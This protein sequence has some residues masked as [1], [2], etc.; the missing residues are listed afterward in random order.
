M[1]AQPSGPTRTNAGR[2]YAEYVRAIEDLPPLP[3]RAEYPEGVPA[4]AEP[5]EPIKAETGAGAVIASFTWLCAWEVEYLEARDEDAHDRVLA[6][7][8]ALRSWGEFM[9]YPP[10][11]FEQWSAN[12]LAPLDFDDPSGVRTDQPQACSQAGIYP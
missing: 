5:S 9:P 3:A 8:E 2:T 12:V 10:V 6:A 7:E 11:D 1:R 4:T